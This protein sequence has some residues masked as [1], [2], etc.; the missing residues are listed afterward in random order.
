METHQAKLPMNATNLSRSPAPRYEMTVHSITIQNRKKFF[1][2]L[3]RVLLFPLLAKRPVSMMRTAGKSWSGTE[4]RIAAEY[5]SWT[6][7]IQTSWFISAHCRIQRVTY[8]LECAAV[9]QVEQDDRLDFRAEGEVR[10]GSASTK[11]DWRYR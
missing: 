10:H 5:R 1:S 6:W 7:N 11:Q 8:H 2:H 3:T 9:R 4:R